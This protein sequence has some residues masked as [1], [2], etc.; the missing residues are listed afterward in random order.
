MTPITGDRRQHFSL[1]NKWRASFLSNLLQ[2]GLDLWE[3]R[4]NQVHGDTPTSKN[5]IRR[6]KALARAKDLHLEGSESVPLN[7]QRL[8]SNFD[9]RLEGRT[10]AIEMWIELVEL[11]QKRQQEIQN[12]QAN[13]STLFEFNFTKQHNIPT[14]QLRGFR[15]Q[16]STRATNEVSTKRLQ[17]RVQQNIRRM[18]LL[19]HPNVRKRI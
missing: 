13:Q 6:K 14:K 7:Q 15:H 8:F 16:R 12:E 2:F 10:R 9:N 18:F 17:K 5:F 11:S 4:N 19:P 1:Y 3:Q